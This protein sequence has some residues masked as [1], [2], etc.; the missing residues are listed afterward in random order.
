MRHASLAVLCKPRRGCWRRFASTRAGPLEPFLRTQGVAVLDGGFGTALGSEAQK[1]VLWG[2]QH[3]FRLEGHNRILDVHRSFLDAG[4]DV[5]CSASYQ[6]S[7]EMF[8]N[9]SAF[10]SLPGGAIT[11][12][13]HKLRYA[14]D[15]LRT[16]VELA[17]KARADYWHSEGG[18]RTARLRPLVAASVG[19]AGDNIAIWTGATDAQTNVHDLADETVSLYYRRKLE[20]LARANPDLIVME[21]LPGRR[22]AKL[23]LAALAEVA[24]DM[25]AVLAFICRSGNT[26]AAGDDFGALVAELSTP[27]QLANVIACGLNC[28]APSLVRPLLQHARACAPDATL[29]AYPNSGEKWD[30]REEG[31]C[32]HARG[33]EEV[34][35][36]T[37]ALAMRDWGADVIGGCCRVTPTQI[38]A[39]RDALL[40]EAVA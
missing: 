38:R 7:F 32:W 2:A 40:P 14:N 19:P 26:T 23:A 11:A 17:K 20:V 34:L 4:A 28:T 24:P 27:E 37:H 1:H 3:L 5:I 18:G 15:V 9:A 29:V 31:R 25:P 10:A 35:D 21:T 30:A 16:S 6:A 36:G 13:K 22:E 12:E 8:E 33:D 39:F